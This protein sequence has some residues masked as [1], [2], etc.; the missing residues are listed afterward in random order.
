[1]SASESVTRWI[2]ELKAG[3]E[4]AATRLWNHFYARLVGLAA[5]KLG[6]GRKRVAD[7]EDVVAIAFE[8]FFRRA[9][10][11]QFPRLQD[12]DDLWQLLVKITER[13]ALNQLRN[14]MRQK[15]GAGQ[16]RG[17]SAFLDKKASTIGAGIDRV[18]AAEP[19]AEFAFI[20]AEEFR[21]LLD[22]L[23]DDQLR[24]IALLKYE[25]HTN[26]EIAAK[27]DRSLPTIERRL[28]LIRDTWKEEC[29]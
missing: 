24:E 9:R 19:T 7:E 22:R 18:V 16:V 23:P 4:A 12:R 8:T 5:R 11:Q 15:R 3:Q 6:V 29:S 26:Q 28:R 10:E 17:E 25:G 21:R 1:M 2:D 13:K 20:L 27:T 14:Q